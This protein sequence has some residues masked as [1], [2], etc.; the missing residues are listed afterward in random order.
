MHDLQFSLC[1]ALAEHYAG[2]RKVSCRPGWLADEGSELQVVLF[3]VG[4]GKV[5]VG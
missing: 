5:K 2:L 1:L 3:G 4:M